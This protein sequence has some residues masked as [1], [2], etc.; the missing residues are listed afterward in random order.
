M[1]SGDRNDSPPGAP[2]VSSKPSISPEEYLA[3]ERRAETKSEYF[4]GRVYAMAGASR[5]H[6]LIV[7]N[8]LAHLHGR[9]RAAPCEVYPS[10]MRLK[11]VATGLYTYPDVSVVCGEPELEDEHR[12]TL[13]NPSVLIEVLSDATE[14]YDRGRK[15]EQY[16]RIDSLKEYLLVAQKEP[17]I[18]HYRRHGDREW[19]LAEA[20]GLEAQVDLV[21]VDCVLPLRDVY[22]RVF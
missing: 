7:A 10:D 12:D 8:L 2:S 9:L 1:F 19:L 6:N 22:D 13:I 4:E 15:A 3:A 20:T 18:E 21:S 16:R 5:R 17:H 11:I 14:A